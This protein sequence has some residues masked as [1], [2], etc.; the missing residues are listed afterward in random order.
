MRILWGL[1]GAAAGGMVGWVLPAVLI[2]PHELGALAILGWRM[3]LVPTGAVLGLIVGLVLFGRG[4]KDSPGG[5][6]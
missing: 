6:P 4:D 1:V 2:N 3:L 5:S